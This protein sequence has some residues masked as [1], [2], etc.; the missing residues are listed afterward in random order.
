MD[1]ATA[2]AWIQAS[3]SLNNAA[4]VVSTAQM[5]QKQ[6]AF[7]LEMW[8]RNREANLADWNMQ[9]EYN[10]PSSIMA[11][12]A[13]AGLNPNLI[14][15]NNGSPSPAIKSSEGGTAPQQPLPF[16]DNQGIQGVLSAQLMDAQLQNARAQTAN[17]QADTELKLKNAQATDLRSTGLAIDNKIKDI[18]TSTKIGQEIARLSGLQEEVDVKKQQAFSLWERGNLTSYQMQ[19]MHD[20]NAR[21][22]AMTATNIQ[23]ALERILLMKKQEALVEMQTSLT[24]D[25]RVEV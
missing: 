4:S 22:E 15:G 11:R 2:N 20:E 17:I 10:S 8:N 25:R 19:F 6:R 13:K 1:E 21:R 23:Q 14:Y 16:K 3:N 9:N 5:N 12:Y 7:Y 24:G 18:L